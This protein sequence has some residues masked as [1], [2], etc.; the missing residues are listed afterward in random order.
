[1][2][3]PDGSA[4]SSRIG[5]SPRS[6]R[7]RRFRRSIEPAPTRRTTP[8][9]LPGALGDGATGQVFGAGGVGPSDRSPSG[10]IL[11]QAW[12]PGPV[13]EAGSAPQPPFLL[14]SRF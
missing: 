6:E 9:V 1:K 13:P 3:A 14:D 2:S 4:S 7:S 11:A 5:P 8:N 10:G 12:P